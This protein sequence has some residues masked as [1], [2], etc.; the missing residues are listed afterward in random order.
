[1]KTYVYLV[2]SVNTCNYD[3]SY[4]CK[5]IDDTVGY[6]DPCSR[7]KYILKMNQAIQISDL[8]E[9][10]LCLMH[11]H[12][13]G[14]HFSKVPKFLVIVLVI[15]LMQSKWLILL[16]QLTY[17]FSLWCYMILPVSLMCFFQVLQSTRI[18][19]FKDSSHFRRSTMGFIKK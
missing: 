4:G 12:M 15:L 16:E 5:S 3:P 8:E 2:I 19:I 6:S 14:V 10:L 9:N 13:N 11:C 7:Q 18:K 17:S 1:M